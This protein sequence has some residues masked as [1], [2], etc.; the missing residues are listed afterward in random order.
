VTDDIVKRLRDY[1]H[2]CDYDHTQTPYWEAADEIERLRERLAKMREAFTVSSTDEERRLRA[3][4]RTVVNH[5]REF[6]PER[7]FDEQIE[8][9][10]AIAGDAKPEAERPARGHNRPPSGEP[11]NSEDWNVGYEAGLADGRASPASASPNIAESNDRA[12]AALASADSEDAARRSRL[13]T[14]RNRT[15]VRTP[16]RWTKARGTWSATG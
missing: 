6:G 13:P 3:A 5:W 2:D 1:S 14:S 10:A 11:C 7:G 12:D 4:L 9:V 16:R 8:R 15:T